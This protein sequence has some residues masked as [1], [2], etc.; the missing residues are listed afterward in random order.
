MH[1]GEV[2]C[3]TDESCG[4]GRGLEPGR[5]DSREIIKFPITILVACCLVNEGIIWP[6]PS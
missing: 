4:C 6:F 3:C 5:T 2:G 1:L